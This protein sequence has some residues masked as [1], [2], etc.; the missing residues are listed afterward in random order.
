MTKDCSHVHGYIDPNWPR[1]DNSGSACIIIFGYVPSFTLGVLGVSLF[2]LA[3]LLHSWLLLRYRTWFFSTVVIGTLMEIVGYVFR[4]LAS[5]LNPYSVAYFVGQYFCIV[6]APVF[7]SAAIYSLLTVMIN[8]VGAEYAPLRPKVI[9]WTFVSCDV[10]ATVIQVL[11][12]SLIG[13]AYSNDKDP[14]VPNHI[15]LAGLAFQVLAYAIF[16]V[17][18]ITFIHKAHA[19]L[20]PR[21]RRFAAATLFAALAVYLRTIIRLA[22]TAEGLLMFLS[23]HEAIFGCLEFL[24]II[25]ALYIFVVFHPGRYLAAKSKSPVFKPLVQLSEL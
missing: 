12:A 13:S 11:G 21:L 22:E 9:L 14:N 7:Y 19:A 2:A 20:T 25:L 16:L 4:S 24:P 5:K 6:V 17:L 23:T 3:L 15:L 8:R 1:P 18:Y 10:V